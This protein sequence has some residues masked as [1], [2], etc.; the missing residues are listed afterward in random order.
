MIFMKTNIL[1]KATEIEIPEIGKIKTDNPIV[2]A[3]IATGIASAIAY[4]VYK[5]LKQQKKPPKKK[6][7]NGSTT[8]LE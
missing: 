2:E 1:L 8:T 6:D 3:T 5:T 7:I 4:G